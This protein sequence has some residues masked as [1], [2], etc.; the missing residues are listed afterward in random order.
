MSKLRRHTYNDGTSYRIARGR[1]CQ[2][3]PVESLNATVHPIVRGRP[4]AA[5]FLRVVEQELKIRCYRRLTIKTYL[6]NLRCFLSWFGKRPHRVTRSAVRAFLEFLVDG[7]AESATLGSY[8]SAIRTSF[9]KFCGKDVTAGLATPRRRKRLPVVPSREEV[10]RM[11]DAS[12]CMRDKLLIA[13]MYACGFRVSEVVK[14]RWCDFDFD[15]GVINVRNSKGGV[16]RWVMLPDRY[17]DVLFQMCREKVGEFV[18]PGEALGKH[19]SS[20]TVE[21]VVK[22]TCVNAGVEKDLTPHCLRHAFATH[23]L[24]EGSDLQFVQKMLGHRNLETTTI[25]TKTA[26]LRRNNG[27]SPLDRLD[28]SKGLGK[29]HGKE[30]GKGLAA[31]GGCSVGRLQF[32][33]DFVGDGWQDALASVRVVGNDCFALIEG[34]KLRRDGVERIEVILPSVDV[35]R[36]KCRDLGEKVLNRVGDTSFLEIVY[37]ELLVRYFGLFEARKR[38]LAA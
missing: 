25:Y 26:N 35:W 29:A 22:R 7:G 1:D 28:D 10:V 6:S 4:S 31:L 23:L 38:A 12:S 37:R 30:H 3:D 24:E 19:L 8:I 21:R 36:A 15:R 16:D 18:F 14:L 2:R 32:H 27:I 13:L 17:R 20:R 5:E 34:I 11:L 9:D 33:V